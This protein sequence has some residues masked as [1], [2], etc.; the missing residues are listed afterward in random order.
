MVREPLVAGNLCVNGRGVKCNDF[1]ITKQRILALVLCHQRWKKLDELI[2]I[3]FDFG[4]FSVRDM[5]HGSTSLNTHMPTLA[6]AGDS[7]GNRLM[8]GNVKRA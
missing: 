6:A 5:V 3:A 4:G 8:D 2:E 7:P 1:R